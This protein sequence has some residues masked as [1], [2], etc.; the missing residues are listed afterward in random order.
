MIFKR[1]K[2]L[3]FKK[4][5][6]VPKKT[7]YV[8]TIPQMFRQFLYQVTQKICLNIKAVCA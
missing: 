6:N 3:F 5:Q 7:G 8:P 2:A 1:R 4:T